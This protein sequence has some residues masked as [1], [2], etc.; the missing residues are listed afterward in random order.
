MDDVWLIQ[1]A[2]PLKFDEIIIQG[3]F[4]PLKFTFLSLW[5]ANSWPSK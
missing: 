1:T 3:R 5:S 4:V 2:V